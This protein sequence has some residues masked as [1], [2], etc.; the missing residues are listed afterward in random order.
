MS[1]VREKTVK[2][3]F[4]DE[5]Q[6]AGLEVRT[7][8]VSVEVY[9]EIM[10]MVSGLNLDTKDLANP[11]KREEIRRTFRKPFDLFAE[12]LVSWNLEERDDD[13]TVVAVP[14]T[15]EGIMSDFVF[16]ALVIKEW[17]K[18]V[19]GVSEE[20]G[21]DSGSG[22]TSGPPAPPLP[23]EPLSPSPQNSLVPS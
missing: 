1:Y 8:R 11:Q 13:G 4:D 14:P 18:A 6:L 23:M 3:T 20:L 2:V 22:A 10:M 7:R 16:S 17:L 21:K 9:E 19:N 12:V 5:H 15:I